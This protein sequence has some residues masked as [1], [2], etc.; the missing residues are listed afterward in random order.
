MIS[1]RAWEHVLG[2]WSGLFPSRTCQEYILSWSQLISFAYRITCLQRKRPTCFKCAIANK[3]CPQTTSH[4]NPGEY[5]MIVE[6]SSRECTSA[7]LQKL[8][9]CDKLMDSW[10]CCTTEFLG[11]LATVRCCSPSNSLIARIPTCWEGANIGVSIP[12]SHN[13]EL[14]PSE[15]MLCND[16]VMRVKS[17][18]FSGR[19][20]MLA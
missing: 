9:V 13:F 18:P 15:A 14:Y 5:H 10:T 20:R 3:R 2:S 4:C 1:A 19:G 6:C 12:S 7:L 17:Y 8:Q 16:A 11:G